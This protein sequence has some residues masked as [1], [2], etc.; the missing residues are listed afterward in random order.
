MP[1]PWCSARVDND[2]V[3]IVDDR[4]QPNGV[5]TDHPMRVLESGRHRDIDILF[6]SAT[7]VEVRDALLTLA[8]GNADALWA[9]VT[10]RPTTHGIGDHAADP[11]AHALNVLA[12]FDG[13]DRP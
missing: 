9:P 3:A 11:T 4:D 12:I 5:L 13:I 8:E 10:T 2:V 7:P 1:G 6:S